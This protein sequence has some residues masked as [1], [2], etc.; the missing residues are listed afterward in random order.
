MC[1]LSTIVPAEAPVVVEELESVAVVENDC[2]AVVD[3]VGKR[4]TKVENTDC[5]TR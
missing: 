3:A 2:S 1:E 4:G 5:R